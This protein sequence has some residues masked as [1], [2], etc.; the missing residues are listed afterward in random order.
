MKAIDLLEH[1]LSRADW[2]DRDN[3]VDKIIVGD[4]DKEVGTAV[5]TWISSFAA[6]RAAVDRGVDAL[7]THEPTFY[8][9]RNEMDA[10]NDSDI[11]RQK[12]SFLDQSG[13]VILRCHDAWDRWPDIGIPWAWARFLGLDGEPVAFGSGRAQHRY[14]IPPVTVDELAHR[15]ALKTA[16]IG[17]PSVQVVG[18]SARQV[19]KIGIGTGCICS[20]PEYM[21]MGCDVGVLC[22][23]GAS[24]WSRVQPAEDMGFPVIRVN[25]GTSEEP[26]MV[27]LTQYINDDVPGVAAEHLPHGS[28]FRLVG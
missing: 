10:I 22:D 2:V 3:T 11:S 24:Y 13:L 5:V 18:K 20:V 14:D 27:T 21:S 12:K 25:H 9:H 15:V 6:V 19:S 7:I 4:P 23:D 1:F 26:G 28:C 16:E 17:E 8:S